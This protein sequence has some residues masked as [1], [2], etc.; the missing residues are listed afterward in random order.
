M[1]DQTAKQKQATTPPSKKG[2]SKQSGGGLTKDQKFWRTFC[3]TTW[4]NRKVVEGERV[5]M[6]T[7]AV[8]DSRPADGVPTAGDAVMVRALLVACLLL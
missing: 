4:I 5:G 1:A 8:A 2:S 7:Y 6:V 3:S